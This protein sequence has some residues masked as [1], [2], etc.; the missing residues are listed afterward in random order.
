MLK[1][2]YNLSVKNYKIILVQFTRMKKKVN[3]VLLAHTKVKMN[4]VITV[5]PYIKKVRNF[6]SQTN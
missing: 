6:K 1:N 4:K 3:L 2:S 5:H